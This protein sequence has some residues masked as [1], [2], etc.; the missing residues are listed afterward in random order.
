MLVAGGDDKVMAN[1]LPMALAGV[2][3]A[4]LLSLPGSSVASWEEMRGLFIAR[5]AAPMP[6]A[7]A[8]LGGSQAPPLD[9]HVKQFFRQ[10]GATRVQQG[11]PPG[12]AAPKADLTIDL[13]DHPTTT[14]GAGALLMLRTP[15]ICNVAVTKTLIDRGA[16]L[17]VLSMEAFGLLHVPHGRLRP[18]K[19]FSRVVNGPTSPLGQIRLPVTFSTR[20]NYRTELIDFD[21]TRIGLPYNA[22]LGYPALAKF[23][24]ATH[25]AYNLMMMP[26]SSGVLTVAGDTKEAL[27]ALKLAFRAAAVVRPSE[28]GAPEAPGAAPAKKKQ[29][30]SQDDA[31]MKQVSVDE[32]GASGA[33]FTIG[34]GLPSD[35][36]E[37][38]VSFLCKNK[39]VFAWE[40]KDLVRIPRGII[41]H[42][43]RVCPNVCP[44]KQKVRR[45]STEKHSFI[46]QETRKL[47]D[48]GVIREVRYPEWLAN[49]VVVPK[50]GGKERMCVDFTNL[51]KACPQDPFPLPRIDQIVDF[52]AECDMLCFLDAFSG[53]QQIKMT[54]QDVEKT[55]FLTPCGVY[56][57][58]CMPFGLRNAGATFQG[59][60]HIA[61]GQQLG[62]NAE[63][64]ID[65]IVVKSREARTLMEDLEETFASLRKVDLRLNPEK[66]VFGVPSGKLLGFLVSHRRIDANPEKVKA[67]ERMSP[68]QTLK[69]M[70]KLAG[71]VTSLGRFISKLGERALPFFKLMKKKGSFEW[72]PEANAGFQDLKRYL[73]SPPVMVASRPLEPLVLYL[74][75]TPHFANAALVAVREER[76]AKGL[77]RDAAHP[78]KAA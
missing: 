32:D 64:Y 73:T 26:E 20:D 66:C 5:F 18:T 13:R 56:C 67:I 52:T 7:V 45:E 63:A 17:N 34:A 27:L 42:H 61:L 65:D 68:P 6:H 36:E 53:Y 74:S 22:I 49:L 11:A 76:Q 33:T 24:A 16:I 39:D 43:L 30:F 75:A 59:L 55:A 60:M 47:Q 77:P 10:V 37:A 51:N 25:P 15:T 9:R 29:L 14:A 4:W 71:C 54:V 48:A 62:R 28:E 72:T 38:L 35:Q 70:Q 41:E 2:P 57:Y 40:P 12:W 78:A 31:E 44:A 21:I 3:R 69:E 46:V 58:T 8:A 50:K 1:W 19:P 23:M